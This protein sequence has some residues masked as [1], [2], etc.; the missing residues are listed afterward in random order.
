MKDFPFYSKIALANLTSFERYCC[1]HDK[2]NQDIQGDIASREQMIFATKTCFKGVN[3]SDIEH[4]KMILHYAFQAYAHDW[5]TCE[6]LNDPCNAPTTK[7]HIGYMFL[8]M[9]LFIFTIFSNL[10]VILAV[11]KVSFLRDN[12]GNYLISSLAFSDLFVGLF[13]I[14]IKINFA[15]N[16]L[17]FCSEYLCRFYIT[18]DTAFF[19][20]SITNLFCISIDRYLAL[21]FPYRYTKLMTLT[22]CKVLIVFIWT[23]GVA[24]GLLSNVNWHDAKTTS[25]HISGYQ[26]MVNGNPIYVGSVYVLVFYIPAAVMAV[27][28]CRVL[29][30]A[31]SHAHAISELISVNNNSDSES[32]SSSCY[33]NEEK[34]AGEDSPVLQYRHRLSVI[35]YNNTTVVN[36]KHSHSEVSKRYSAPRSTQML[37]Y[38]KMIFKA[39]KTVAT[40]YGTFLICWFPVS[41]VSLII[42]FCSDC[43]D[44]RRLKWFYLVFVEILPVVSSMVNPL[45]YG[46][47]NKQYRRAYKTIFSKLKNSGTRTFSRYSFRAN[48]SMLGKSPMKKKST[49]NMTK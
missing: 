6:T 17:H 14:P 26:C 13:I 23:Y 33:S 3:I 44:E 19:S 4:F 12:I 35:T 22:R 39:S 29:S 28:Y 1:L 48:T 9:V 2:L 21:N 10:T 18:A 32:M 20:T 45:I 40:A 30:I 47:M 46:V 37:K 38:R 15:Y 24:W 36:S 11:Q 43:V 27:V 34:A 41:A 49:T 42:P 16:N 25:I 7:S 31:R 8:W 5:R